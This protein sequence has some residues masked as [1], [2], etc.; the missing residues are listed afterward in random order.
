VSRQYWRDV[1]LWLRHGFTW[2]DALAV[3][4]LIALLFV[5]RFVLQIVTGQ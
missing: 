2:R 3:A 4:L 5:T 1:G